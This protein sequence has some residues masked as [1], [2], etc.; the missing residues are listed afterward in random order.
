MQ[1]YKTAISFK[2]GKFKDKGYSQDNSFV[3]T[4]F[5]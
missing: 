5:R 4:N 2:N 3:L 1:M